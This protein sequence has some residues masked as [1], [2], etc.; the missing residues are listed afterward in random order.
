MCLKLRPSALSRNSTGKT[1][2]P[3]Q[4]RTTNSD[5]ASEGETSTI[6][7]F[8]LLI[9]FPFSDLPWPQITWFPHKLSSGFTGLT[10]YSSSLSSSAQELSAL[11]WQS[12]DLA[13]KPK[14]TGKGWYTF[15]QLLWSKLKWLSQLCMYGSKCDAISGSFGMDFRVQSTDS[16]SV[17]F[18]PGHIHQLEEQ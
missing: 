12:G 9:S 16:R 7:L 18:G 11:A 10:L 2:A 4:G 14:N 3:Q 1:W 6:N 17:T 8:I 15:D 13:H 5:D